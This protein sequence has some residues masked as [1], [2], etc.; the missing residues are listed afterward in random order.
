MDF[1]ARGSYQ[2]RST[3]TKSSN[4]NKQ[5]K[6]DSDE[7]MRLSDSEIAGCIND[8]GVPFSPEDLLRPQPAQIQKVFEWFAELLMNTTRET[9]EPA[10]RAAADD[11]VGEE[12][13]DIVPVETRNLMGFYASLRK[14]LS[15]CG[16]HD[17]SFSD[18]TKP[19]HPRIVKIFSYIINFVRFRESQT[20][21]IDAHFN[22][23]ESTK[24][25]IETIYD[26]NRD[27]ESR[28]ESLRAN[29]SSMQSAVKAKNARTEDLK[30]K[31]LALKK[32]QEQLQLRMDQSRD[33][34]KALAAQLEEKVDRTT[35]SRQDAAKL[36]PYA[37]QSISALQ[38]QLDDLNSSLTSD[39]ST[40]GSLEK[41]SR[42][43]QTS[44]DT[45]SLASNDVN[46]L[47][48]SL[49]AVAADLRTEESEA[50]DAARRR[51]A[52][53]DR[54]NN[55]RAVERDERALQKQLETWLSRTEG[56]RKTA[57]EKGD[58]AQDRMGE[59]TEVYNGLVKERGKSGKEVERKRIRIE[60]TE[61]KMADLKENIEAEVNAAK[62]EYLKMD[63]H[64][65]LYIREMEQSMNG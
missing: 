22:K 40:I 28:L 42:A 46:P 6:D 3:V 32:D 36:R 10:M 33:Q 9:V 20:G 53:T 18:L 12:L 52:L 39:R 27:L 48:T 49:S 43:L 1:G 16:I 24:A 45:F 44:A 62:D 54:S 4:Q 29:Q 15:E 2:S 21:T 31:L 41:R 13:S 56:L 25:R 50:Q 19:T 57:Q 26:E 17:F 58:K 23:R 47:L 64:I 38:S 8:I 63:A 60:Q 34:K 14:L 5:K 65:R 55:V 11:I 35:Q 37:N 59:L 51:D 30:I 7:F 61:K